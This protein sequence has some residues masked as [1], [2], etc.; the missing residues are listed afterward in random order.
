MSVNQRIFLG[1]IVVAAIGTIVGVVGLVSSQLSTNAVKNLDNLQKEYTAFS[2]ILNAHYSWRNGLTE[3]VMVGTAFKGSL[4]PNTCALGSWLNS[5]AAKKITD[6]KIHSLLDQIKA[7]HNNIHHGAEPIIKKVSDGN[8]EDA[9]NELFAVVYP[10][11][12][13]V[14]EGLNAARTR[15]NELMEEKVKGTERLETFIFTVIVV[16]I[17]AAVVIAMILG[18]IISKSIVKP[19]SATIDGLAEI[20]TQVTI[21]AGEISGISQ[22]MADSM[23]GKQGAQ[24]ASFEEISMTLNNLS[25]MTKQT[26]DNVYNA[27]I[28]VKETGSKVNVGKESMDRLQKAVIEI[29]QSS[30]ETV[31]ILKDIDE[32]AFQTNLLALNAAVEAARAGEAGKGFAVVAEEVRNLAQRSAESAKKT[33][34]LIEISQTKS[35]AGVNLV[36]ETAD[37]IS[38]IAE[39]TAKINVIISDI[40]SASQ[41][42]A[43]SISQVNSAIG[44]IEQIVQSSKQSSEELAA[45]SQ[46]LNSHASTMNGL[47]GDLVGVVDGEAAKAERL[48]HHNTTVMQ[49]KITQSKKPK[50]VSSQNMPMKPQPLISFDDD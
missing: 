13:E 6:P 43:R 2:N 48:K 35:Q 16:A 11:L 32:I 8:L 14:I 4:D 19:I 27:D 24:T 40:T 44:T 29:Q 26:A 34:E 41:E 49:R 50:A 37:A 38:Q 23:E 21:A 42:Q 36:G 39:K 28:L 17:V 22:S 3:T 25:G 20:S 1:F 7:P 31:K 30:S 15:Y 45:D 18:A 9:K 10:Q 12:Q 33:A 46:E 47:M 5:D